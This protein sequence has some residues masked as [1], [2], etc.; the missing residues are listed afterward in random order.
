MRHRLAKTDARIQHDAVLHHTTAHQVAS[1]LMQESSH[2]PY[3]FIG[4]AL[5]R[6]HLHGL[7]IKVHVHQTNA[8]TAVLHHHLLTVKPIRPTV[9]AQGMNVV[10]DV[11]ARIEHGLHHLGLVSIHR[12]SHLETHGLPH[13]RKHAAQL[14]L[15]RHCSSTWARRLC[16]Y[17]QNGGALADQSLGVQQ[18]AARIGMLPTVRKRIGCDIDNPHDVGKLQVQPK[19]PGLPMRLRQLHGMGHDFVKNR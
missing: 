5:H 14:F 11:G 13:H 9:P 12:N 2:I 17:V 19:T 16:A 8:A 15:Q 1:P 3:H 7:G 6:L 10:D 18:G 4:T